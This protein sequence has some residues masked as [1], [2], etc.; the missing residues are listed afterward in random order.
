MNIIE[1][2]LNE[3]CYLDTVK[4]RKATFSIH[5]QKRAEAVRILQERFG[6]PSDKNFIDALEYDS[7]EGVDFGRRDVKIAKEIYGYSKGAAIGRIKHS[8]K[9]VKM[10][11]TTED[12]AAPLPP[13]I[14]EHYKNI[15]L[16]IDILYLNQTPFLLAIS[17][18]IGCIHCRPMSNNVTKRIQNTIK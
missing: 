8:R 14:I 16:D 17:S 18:D 6:F 5:D 13:N 2:E 12:V 10:D 9:G 3:H 15:H 7:I 4:D 11:K 1:A